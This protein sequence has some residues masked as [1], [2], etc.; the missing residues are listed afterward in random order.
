MAKLLAL[1]VA[2]ACLLSFCAQTPSATAP[3][4]LV[5]SPAAIDSPLRQRLAAAAGA[6]VSCVEVTARYMKHPICAHLAHT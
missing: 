6:A 5:S 4:V 1:L 3:H 2:G